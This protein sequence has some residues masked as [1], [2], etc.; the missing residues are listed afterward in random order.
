V[1]IDVP[2]GAARHPASREARASGYRLLELEDQHG[3][4]K[5]FFGGLGKGDLESPTARLF[6]GLEPP[7]FSRIARAAYPPRTNLLDRPQTY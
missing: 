1:V 4:E 5:G 3:R 2:A 6:G 7:H